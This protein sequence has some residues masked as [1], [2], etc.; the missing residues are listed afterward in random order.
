MVLT[1]SDFWKQRE[2]QKSIETLERASRLDPANARILLDLGGTYG[3]RYDY[4]AAERCFEQAVRVALRKTEAL[5][6]AGERCC[7][8]NQYEMAERFFQRVVAQKDALPKALV[9]LAEI[10]ERLRRLDTA[11]ELVERAL[12]SDAHY[13]PALLARARLDRKAGRL[14]EVEKTLKSFLSNSCPDIHLEGWY[15]LSRQ[16]LIYE[17]GTNWVGFWINWGDMTRPWQRSWKPSLCCA[18]T[19]GGSSPHSRP[20]TGA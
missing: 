12:H 16:T 9:K 2:F 11:N 13:A 10:H 3:L 5:A 1:A 15:E 7:Q 19:P 8:F 4:A 6:A 20:F 18:P 14:E 17:A